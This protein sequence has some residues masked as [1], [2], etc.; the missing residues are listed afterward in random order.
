MLF[1]S[2]NGVNCQIEAAGE[3]HAAHYPQRVFGKGIARR[4]QNAIAQIFLS[5]KEIE[6]LS[7]GRIVR[8]RPGKPLRGDRR[9]IR[10]LGA[11]RPV[12]QGFDTAHAAPVSAPASLMLNRSEMNAVPMPSRSAWASSPSMSRGDF[13]APASV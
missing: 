10:K 12:I 2:C 3:L 6:Q 8:Q 5:T 4:P 7:G 9:V 11:E 13:G 1:R